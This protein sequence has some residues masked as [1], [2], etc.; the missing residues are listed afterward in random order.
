[1]ILVLFILTPFTMSFSLTLFHGFRFAQVRL[2]VLMIIHGFLSNT[3]LKAI[4]AQPSSCANLS[5]LWGSSLES[6]G[7]FMKGF[8]QPNAVYIRFTRI[9]NMQPKYY[10]G[11]DRPLTAPRIAS[12]VEPESIFNMTNLSKPNLHYDLGGTIKTSLLGPQFPFLF[13]ELTK[14]VSNLP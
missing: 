6:H 4:L 14:D 9:L 8:F 1:M 2:M 12:T 10:V 13:A 3:K 7:L 11:S 5:N